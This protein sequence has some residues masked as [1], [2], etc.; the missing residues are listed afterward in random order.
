MVHLGHYYSDISRYF[1][2]YGLYMVLIVHMNYPLNMRLCLVL[3]LPV[4][5]SSTYAATAL[6]QG[7]VNVKNG[8]PYGG[9]SA[10]GD[11]VH[12][13]TQAFFDAFLILIFLVLLPMLG[14]A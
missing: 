1:W 9:A 2:V 12:H 13:D 3:F 14:V 10:V 5:H 11:G 6:S 7:A 4:T 8:T